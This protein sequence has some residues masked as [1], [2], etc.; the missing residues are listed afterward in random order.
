MSADLLAEFGHRSGPAQPSA[1]RSE[2]QPK[3]NALLDAPAQTDDLLSLGSSGHHT[4]R[5]RDHNLRVQSSQ[6]AA[7]APQRKP[8]FQT[9]DLPHRHDSDLLFDATLD[10]PASDTEDDWGEFEGPE[11]SVA[12]SHPQ[13]LSSINAKG[14]PISESRSHQIQDP[15][16]TIDLLDS[17]SMED[18]AP[19]SNPPTREPLKSKQQPQ[20]KN[21]PSEP[22]WDD[23]SFGDWD[24]FADETTSNSPPVKPNSSKKQFPAQPA[25]PQSMWED[26]EDWG[27]FNDGPSAR[28]ALTKPNQSSRPSTTS[29]SSNIIPGTSSSSP[30]TVRPT[31]IPPPSVL[32]E[33]LVDIFNNLQKEAAKAKARDTAHSIKNN[34]ASNIH[35]TL[36]T[37]AR[38]IAGRTLRWKRDTILSQSMR[39]G[40]AR[41]GKSSGMKLN[42]V[43][44]HEDVK[45]K[46]DAVDVLSLWRERAALFNTVIQSAGRRPIPA[47]ADPSALKV[48]T[49]RPEAGAIKA[50]HPCALCALKRDERVLKLD[51]EDVQDSFGEWWTE[52][53]GHTAC[54]EFWEANRSLLG[55]R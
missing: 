2:A 27:D 16:G 6:Q 47:V 12:P 46:Q 26:D 51:D 28:P 10:A 7:P 13:G 19:A 29:P 44:K 20:L 11:S 5:P 41:A 53:W 15:S 52:H 17:L 36:E 39:I 42:A 25:P 49:G 22:T 31:N 48:I 30:I 40:P 24:E 14:T 8:A 33:L 54:H 9:F 45:E 18:Q 38:I 43:N 4:D 37:A 34:T 23:D 1:G 21:P 32:L 35:N 55:Q 3:A 50:S